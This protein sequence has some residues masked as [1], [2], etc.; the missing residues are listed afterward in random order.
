[1]A[2]L[3]TSAEV[4]TFLG[5]SGVDYS[6]DIAR[7]SKEIEGIIGNP[8]VHTSYTERLDGGVLTLFL[9]RFP[10]LES[11]VVV[12]D[13]ETNTTMSTSDV[14]VYPETGRIETTQGYFG[15]GRRR[16]EVTYTAGICPDTNSVPADIKRATLLLIKEYRDN[17][18]G[19]KSEKIGDYSYELFEGV[20]V[21]DDIVT[22]LTPY[23]RVKGLL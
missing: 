8:V 9:S 10:V 7:A 16:W 21:K 22:L 13:K 19:K 3:V 2:D 6:T 1:M 11:S 12:K 14:I 18:S 15:V 17:T 4:N 20:S 23:R 5:T